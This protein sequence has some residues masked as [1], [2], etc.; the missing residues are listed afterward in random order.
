MVKSFMKSFMENYGP[1]LKNIKDMLAELFEKIIKIIVIAVIVAVLMFLLL[2]TLAFVS[3]GI[4]K[5]SD[6]IVLTL[7][8]ETELDGEDIK[9]SRVLDIDKNVDNVAVTLIDI[10]TS[11]RYTLNCTLDYD[12]EDVYKELQNLVIGDIIKHNSNLEYKI[13]HTEVIE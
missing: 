11:E 6:K 9:V 12:N 13:I 2:V 3:M 4:E 7:A 5:L 8:S 10:E 1:V